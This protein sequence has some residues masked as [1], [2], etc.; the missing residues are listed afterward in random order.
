[1]KKKFKK[2]HKFIPKNF[3]GP[4]ILIPAVKIKTANLT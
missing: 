2:S 1:M 3:R 4:K